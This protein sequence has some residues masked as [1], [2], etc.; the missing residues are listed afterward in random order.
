MLLT[1]YF[2][3]LTSNSSLLTFTEIQPGVRP[4]IIVYMTFFAVSDGCGRSYIFAPAQTRL[5]GV[6]SEQQFYRH[7]DDGDGEDDPDHLFASLDDYVGPYPSTGPVSHGQ[8][9]TGEPPDVIG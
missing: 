4:L 6:C 9:R 5:T 8:H 2:L 1:S 3:L 7:G